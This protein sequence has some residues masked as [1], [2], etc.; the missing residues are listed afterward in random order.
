MTQISWQYQVN[1][2]AGG[3]IVTNTDWNDVAGDLRALIDQTTSSTTDNTPLPIGIDLVNDRVYISDPD[4]TTPEDGNHADTTLSV[5][6]TTTLAGA[7]QQTGTFTVGVDDTGHDFK[8]FGAT[9]GAYLLWDE[10]ADQLHAYNSLI[11][12]GNTTDAVDMGLVGGVAT[13]RGINLGASAYNDLD[14]RST[15]GTQLYLD[16]SGSVGIGSEP[17][18]F[19]HIKQGESG[20]TPAA[21]HHIFGES[22]GD[23]GMALC[24]GTGNNVYI[25]MGDSADSAEGGFNYDNADDSLKILTNNKDYIQIKS[26]GNVAFNGNGTT[27]TTDHGLVEINQPADNDE[28][29][30]AV[31]A[32]A[33]GRTVRLWASD[34]GVGYL[35]CG[36][37]GVHT[38]TLNVGMGL[39]GVGTSGP[40]AQLHVL[41]TTAW[42]TSAFVMHVENVETANSYGNGLLIQAGNPTY[43]TSSVSYPLLVRD[44]D[45]NNI[46]LCRADGYTSAYGNFHVGGALSKVSGTFDIPHPTRGGDWRL[47]HSFIEGPQADLIYRGTVTLSGGTATIDLDT[48]SNMTDGTW[49]ALCRDPWAMVASSGNAVEW[50]LSGKTLTITSDTADAVCSWMVIGERQD[51]HMKSEQGVHS[52]TDGHLI[53]EYEREPETYLVPG[54]P[55]EPP[56]E[57]A[58]T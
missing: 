22:D 26:T 12:A 13:I 23:M 35:S 20:A 44:K 18:A 10:S 4:S 14:I 27:F 49:E 30:L 46:F 41:N 37:G 53:V 56:S 45:G 34:A 2:R 5:V 19:L 48:A 28:S 32:Y 55:P 51:D 8:A 25:R 6:G 9:S 57:E 7:T 15:S 50:S 1:N 38:L 11:V 43:G 54:P 47:R 24:G 40:D 52:D 3:Y 42:N 58:A 17:V 16:T 36:D 29:G 33:N 21:S 31:R 39:V